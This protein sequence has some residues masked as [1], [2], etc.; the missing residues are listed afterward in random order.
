MA[1]GRVKRV[2][3]GIGRGER[4]VAIEIECL[5]V[6]VVSPRFSDDVDE[7]RVGA[8]DLHRCAASYDLKLA[9]G[10]LRKEKYGVITTALIALKRIIEIRSVNRY[11]R[12]D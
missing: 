5:P 10:G 3:E 11:V 9:H 4:L 2:V 7:T 6:P 1:L 8:P 12:I